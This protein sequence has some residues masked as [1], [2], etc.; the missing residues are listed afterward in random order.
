MYL[1]GRS[2]RDDAASHLHVPVWLLG[3]CQLDCY[4]DNVPRSQSAKLPVDLR[5][6]F[7][8]RDGV[9]NEKMLEGRYVTSR[10]EFRVLPGVPEAIARLNRTGVRAIVVSN[11]RG[12]ALGLYGGEDVEQI[13]GAF[14][15]ELAGHSAHIDA[16]FMCPHDHDACDCRKPLPGLFNQATAFFPDITVESS[17]MIGDS[18]VDMEFGR[19][20]GMATILIEGAPK[21]QTPGNASAA[22]AL[23][24]LRFSS[25]AQ[26][27]DALLRGR[28]SAS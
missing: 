8:D 22:G 17:V 23:A 10:E 2:L 6:V 28:T 16:F 26:A 4:D 27:V 12:I 11:Q 5:T 14:Q 13:H 21:R 20:L 25:L 9:L 18:L 3:G 15:R 7:L 19:N 1:G 24:D